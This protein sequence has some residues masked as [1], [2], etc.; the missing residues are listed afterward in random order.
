M[1]VKNAINTASQNATADPAVAAGAATQ[2]TDDVNKSI[3]AVPSVK[4]FQPVYKNLYDGLKHTSFNLNKSYK[5]NGEQDR[6]IKSALQAGYQINPA[7]QQDGAALKVEDLDTQVKQWTYGT[8]ELTLYADLIQQGVK[9]A[10]STVYQYV[11]FLQHG[12]VGHRRF[13]PEIGI[14]DVNSPRLRKEHVDMKYLTDV[15]Q[16]SYPMQQAQTLSDPDAMLMEDAITVIAKSIEW[17]IFYGDSSLTQEGSSEGLEFDGLE[18]LI[19]PGNHIDARGGS[20]T[21][22][23]LNKAAV[24]VGTRGFGNAT[25]AYMSLPVKADFVNQYLGAQRWLLGSR[26]QPN[27][28]G[29][30]VGGDI[31]EYVSANGHIKLHGSAIIDID[32]ILDEN[33]NV[34]VNSPEPPT[35]SAEATSDQGGK[36]LTALDKDGKEITDMTGV[37]QSKLSRLPEVGVQQS[38]KAVTVDRYGDSYASE[39]ATATPSASTD[40]VRLTVSLGASAHRIP[41]YVAIYRKGTATGLYYLIKRIPI[42]A[43]NAQGEIEFMDLDDVIPETSDVFVGELK[44]STISLVEFIP[45]CQIPLATVNTATQ[46]AIYWGGA[47]ALFR[48]RCWVQLHN[49]RN[50]TSA[51]VDENHLAGLNTLGYK[52]R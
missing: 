41:D 19:D 29:T 52:A 45:L 44:P 13:Q 6:A 35:L 47:L 34:G 32:R 43:M 18:K 40:G 24:L 50:N 31:D 38:Y 8:Q 2:G 25:D 12:R 14:T 5:A 51:P 42:T 23:L 20:L 46:Y 48:P 4:D 49:V 1:N 39:E 15:K 36:F 9:N 37:D 22:E 17:G 3:P 21:P 11:V 16:L 10:Q 7:M 33:N 28:D 26:V 30:V 27:L